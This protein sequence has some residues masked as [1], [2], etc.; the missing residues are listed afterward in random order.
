MSYVVI[1]ISDLLPLIRPSMCGSNIASAG[2]AV[3]ST[4][5]E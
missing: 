3:N 1:T 4:G 2:S 5:N